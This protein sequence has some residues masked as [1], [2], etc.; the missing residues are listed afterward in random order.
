MGPAATEGPQA[1]REPRK[2]PR[3]NGESKD[4]PRE[5]AC[6]YARG[7]WRRRPGA[8]PARPP[9]GVRQ[10]N[11]S[12]HR[13][14]RSGRRARGGPR[15]G[16]SPGKKNPLGSPCLLRSTTGALRFAP[17]PSTFLPPHGESRA[18]CRPRPS[19]QARRQSKSPAVSRR[20]SRLWA[21]ACRSARGSCQRRPGA[22]PARPPRGVRQSNWS[23]HRGGR[24]GR[25]ARGGPRL[26][27]SP[28]KKN[29]SRSPCLFRST[30]GVLPPHGESR[31]RCRPRPSVQARRQS[32]SPAVSR[33]ASRLCSLFGVRSA[34]AFRRFR[35]IPRPRRPMR[36]TEGSGTET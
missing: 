13:G 36:A 15:L 16:Q 4:L 18:R 22:G 5:G 11:W 1:G 26:G 34:Y 27:Q 20:A 24:S 10:S 9:R 31:A 8:G 33:R 30:T 35:S 23:E 7:S 14:G 21:S 32:K 3:K 17:D 12:E 2:A 6:G 29:P 25:R 28:G 19:V